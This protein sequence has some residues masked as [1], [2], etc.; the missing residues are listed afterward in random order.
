MLS[1]FNKNFQ[2]TAFTSGQIVPINE[3]PD[4]VF[5]Q[6][7]MGEGIAILPSESV[8]YAP[9]DAEVT[10]LMEAS[11]HAIGLTCKNGVQILLHVGVDT[12]AMNGEGFAYAVKLHDSVKQGD[13][14]IS[15]DKKSIKNKGYTDLTM[16]ILLDM[17]KFKTS[18]F[19]DK[20]EVVA[21]KS[22]ITTL[23]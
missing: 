18:E 15:F 1:I 13:R 8:I 20:M 11:K 10:V 6:K 16:M 23:K 17:G 12:V 22:V 7:L 3:V 4:E 2:L 19:V 5:S 14:L 9:C 21:G